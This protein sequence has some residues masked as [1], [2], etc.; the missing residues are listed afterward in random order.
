MGVVVAALSWYADHRVYVFD[1]A[2]ITLRYASRIAEGKGF[3]YND[4]EA[5]NG[6]SNPLF[7]LVEAALLRAGLSPESTIRLISAVCLGLTAA[8]LLCTF[9][10]FYSLAA[11]AFSVL[12][13]VAFPQTFDWPLQGM[14]T[15]FIM[16]FGALLFRALHARGEI[17]TGLVLGIL[18]ANKLDGALAAV[19]FATVFFIRERRPPWR[20][21]AF[22]F[23]AAAPMFALLIARFG[24]ILPNSMIVKLTVHSQAFRMDPL[25]M[26]RMLA[27][28]S[29]GVLYLGAWASILVLPILRLRG[30]MP[31][32][33]LQVWFVLHLATYALVN[34]GDTFPWYT[35]TP[36]FLAVVLSALLV[37]GLA[38]APL[39]LPGA[40]R[41]GCA[42][43]EV[44]P[45]SRLITFAFS[46]VLLWTQRRALEAALRLDRSSHSMQ[47]WTQ[48]ALAWELGR[49][50]AGVWLREHTSGSEMLGI[51]EGLPAFEYGGPVYDYCL[52]N[53]KRDEERVRRAA[54]WL[55]GPDRSDAPPA[56][57]LAD[58]RL[59]ATFRYESNM[60]LYLLYARRDSEIW[61]KGIR[62]FVHRTPA[63][64][65]ADP[66]AAR[67]APRVANENQWRF[68]SKDRA[69]FSV[70]SP[71]PPTLSFV[72]H[73]DRARAA[74]RVLVRA[75]GI[76]IAEREVAAGDPVSAL[77]ALPP[78]RERSGEY[79]FEID[80]RPVGEESSPDTIVDLDEVLLRSGEPLHASDFRLSYP[81]SR[82]R[83]EHVA[84]IGLP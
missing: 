2:G 65:R 35:G 76:A 42:P 7:V 49:Q 53:S 73:V 30:R 16:L 50:S 79:R 58:R 69:S 46:A 67:D 77:A 75:N 6:A 28:G 48:N 23:L 13:L 33:V 18:V 20:V 24:S 81:C 22:A 55:T 27:D 78:P 3:G 61:R 41:A 83:I 84:S 5:V 45:R 8:I 12:A 59:V 43:N 82:E 74:V 15:P 51:C 70:G 68:L 54:Y 19:A 31:T 38:R 52:L 26:H 32:E 64:V 36:I 60:G 80:C 62:H 29:F 4:G 10:H 40:Y 44:S 1:D 9:E 14:E 56:E 39:P 21:A 66:A 34:L 37:D 11:A 57:E 71:D 63:L 72:P 25:W 17:W 47:G